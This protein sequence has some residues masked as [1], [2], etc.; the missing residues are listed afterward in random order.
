MNIVCVYFQ[1]LAFVADHPA[2]NNSTNEFYTDVEYAIN[3]N[4]RWQ[5]RNREELDTFFGTVPP[6]LSE[7][8]YRIP[9]AM[10]PTHYEV[11]FR[12][13]VY[14]GDVETFGFTGT[15]KMH[16][17]CVG[18]TNLINFHTRQLELDEESLI[19]RSEVD[20]SIT[21]EHVAIT[22]NEITELVTIELA[23][24]LEVDEE[25]VVEISY[26]G[27]LLNDMSGMYYSYYTDETDNT[28]K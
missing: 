28:L 18:Q 11:R 21:Y 9:A 20:E 2:D 14:T 23:Q 5:E 25:I 1:F 19:I 3:A 6:P 16:L 15:V 22:R 8:N 7:V 26:S 10:T 17:T 27:P 13:D 4:I 24:T 12:A